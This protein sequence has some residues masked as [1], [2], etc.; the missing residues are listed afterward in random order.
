PALAGFA[1]DQR[2]VEVDDVTRRLPDLRG[3]KDAGVEPS[4][5]P[6]ALNKR[7]APKL[8]DVVLQL[9]S[10]WAVIPCVGETTVD[11][12][13]WKDEPPA[14][15]E[16]GDLVHGGSAHRGVRLI[17][18]WLPSKSLPLM[19]WRDGKAVALPFTMYLILI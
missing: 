4:N 16:R 3:H 5:F 14:L 19:L 10:E 1:V 13:T 6:S 17:H 15:A 18:G 8:F 2:I 7:L 9:D 11:F 12:G